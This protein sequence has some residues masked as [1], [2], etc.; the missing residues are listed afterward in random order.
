MTISMSYYYKI[1]SYM[2]NIR[3]YDYKMSAVWY[4][5]VRRGT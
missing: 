2:I 1:L 4:S 5:G 3:A